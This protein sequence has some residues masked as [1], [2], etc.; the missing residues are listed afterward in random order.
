[1]AAS[2]DH[3]Y[4]HVDE[5]HHGRRRT[6]CAFCSRVVLQCDPKFT[7]APRSLERQLRRCNRAR[8]YMEDY[9]K[10]RRIFIRGPPTQT[11]DVYL[12]GG[13]AEDPEPY[14]VVVYDRV[15]AHINEKYGWHTKEIVVNRSQ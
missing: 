14:S 9:Q 8:L 4:C 5:K 6:A 15:I 11:T 3:C 2:K 13:H 10:N 1:M 12:L 7:T